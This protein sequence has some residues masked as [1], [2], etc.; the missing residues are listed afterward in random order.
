MISSTLGIGSFSKVKLAI[1]LRTGHEY[2]LKIISKAS[3]LREQQQGSTTGGGGGEGSHHG[4]SAGSEA[5]TKPLSPILGEESGRSNV[6]MGAGAGMGTVQSR[7]EDLLDRVVATEVDILK[8]I[9]HR[10][11]IEFIAAYD[12][13]RHTYLITE[14][15]NGGELF[16]YV[17]QRERL[18]ESEARAV[19]RQ[20]VGAVEYLHS[21]SIC[22][23]D[24]KLENILV[25]RTSV[26]STTGIGT[27]KS[28]EKLVIKLADFGLATRFDPTASHL[29]TQRCGSEEYAAPELIMGQPYDGRQTDIW[30]LGVILF[31]MLTGE[32]PFD[33]AQSTTNAKSSLAKF[34]G[35]GSPSSSGGSSRRAK[36]AMY[37]R[38]CRGEFRWPDERDVVLSEGVRKLVKGMLG[39][40]AS[41]RWTMEEIVACEWMNE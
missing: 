17:A 32:L 36:I 12:T 25:Q 37:H 23:R 33:P 34:M 10:N 40:V 13:H 1:D 2:A 16:E 7:K 9:H 5:T 27:A 30:A 15:V 6:S 24:L 26:P 8:S 39:P 21:R 14:L 38:I 41:G 29:L 11:I 20:V 19:F 3:L 35:S 28:T 31:G 4:S 22:H 18:E